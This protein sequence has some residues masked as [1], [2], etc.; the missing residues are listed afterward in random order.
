MTVAWEGREGIRPE[1]L[2]SIEWGRCQSCDRA[3]RLLLES[4]LV[5][6]GA[7]ELGEL[8][9]QIRADLET[10]PG[11]GCERCTELRGDIRTFADHMAGRS[12]S[13]RLPFDSAHALVYQQLL[14]RAPGG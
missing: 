11:P 8:V 9:L 2:A 4:A 10:D 3:H 1:R 7:R 14:D 12:H 6:A 13:Y 5:W